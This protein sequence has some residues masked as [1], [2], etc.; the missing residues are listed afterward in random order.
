M[1]FPITFEPLTNP[2]LGSISLSI[3]AIL[4]SIAG[5]VFFTKN[6]TIERIYRHLFSM[7][8][9]FGLMMSLGAAMFGWFFGER[10]GQVIVHEDRFETPYGEFDYELVKNIVIKKELANNSIIS[11]QLSGNYLNKILLFTET[12]ERFTFSE[13]NYPVRKMIR[14]M[15]DTWEKEKTKKN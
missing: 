3:I 6:R 2:L 7:L 12:G 10:V 5:I 1:E 15:R 13:S 14:P 11:P 4:L 8:C 9:F